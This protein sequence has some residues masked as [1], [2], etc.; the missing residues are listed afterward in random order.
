MKP[1]RPA[2]ILSSLAACA[3]LSAPFAA[4][5]GSA[6]ALTLEPTP[7][8]M[9]RLPL[10]GY[11]DEMGRS[12]PDPAQDTYDRQVSDSFVKDSFVKG[13]FRDE[14]PA[15]ATAN[16]V[17]P[18]APVTPMAAPAAVPPAASDQMPDALPAV[19]ATR[20]IPSE[21]GAW[22]EP[23]WNAAPASPWASN[24]LPASTAAPVAS[25]A[26]VA[27]DLAVVPA[28]TGGW[29]TGRADA[30]ATD[31]RRLPVAAGLASGPV[32]AMAASV[33]SPVTGDLGGVPGVHRD[34]ARATGLSGFQPQVAQQNPAAAKS[35]GYNAYNDLG[36]GNMTD[37]SSP[38]QVS[39][40][41]SGVT[42]IAAGGDTGLA[43]Q[44]GALYAW[45]YNTD[46]EVGDGTTTQRAT[47]VP[48][49]GFGSGVTA[50]AGGQANSYAVK[51]GAVYS[52]GVNFNGQLGNGT[53]NGTASASTNATPVAASVLTSGVT[54][55]ASGGYHQL[56]IMN[57]AAY[58]WGGNNFGQVGNG[59]ISTSVTTPVQVS[60][61]GS[62]VTAV[63]TGTYHSLAIQNGSVK[64]WGIDQY[65]E[66]GNNSTTNGGASNSYPTPVQ[67]IGL[68]TGVTA[69]AA[70]GFFSLAVKGGN[71]YSWGSN[72]G[73][74]LGNG[75]TT[76]VDVPTMIDPADLKNITAVAAGNESSYALSSDGSLWVWG[77]NTPQG[78]GTEGLLGLGTTTTQYL[79][80][81]HLLP[82]TG[83][84]YTAID[85]DAQGDFVDA[86]LTVNPVPEPAT[87][88]G[89]ALLVLAAGC[90]LRRPRRA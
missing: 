86:I 34:A 19:T 59:T 23:G 73:G 87:W 63:A 22:M 61:L 77:S 84:I 65:S 81:Q 82:P 6:G 72:A 76:E 29:L 88:L 31:A 12:I 33:A 64:A 71:V 89:G 36:N 40:L 18:T 57:G 14:A 39:N 37:T 47:P 48:I 60:G 54:A 25:V 79:T 20:A 68:T 28:V 53:T 24:T 85:T 55:I 15:R 66:L 35:W 26:N 13:S 5:A 80:P 1:R 44:N 41:T 67:A 51:N 2:A 11:R 16:R 70:G 58:G 45:G 90:G 50:I 17:G 27:N 75:T 56:A 46:G 52:W 83:Y 3:A 62:G 10:A 30:P 9:I 8:W 4:R 74:A 49:S 69:V 42:L 21:P 32:A 78:T 7:T 43:V 38:G